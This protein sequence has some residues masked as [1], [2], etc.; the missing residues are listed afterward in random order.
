MLLWEKENYW[1]QKVRVAAWLT[2]DASYEWDSEMKNWIISSESIYYYSTPTTVVNQLANENILLYP[3]PTSG[4]L[5]I[6][7]INNSADIDVYSINGHMLK[8]LQQ[9]NYNIDMSEFTSGVYILRIRSNN[10][11]IV[12]KVIKD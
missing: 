3:N 11:T 12:R 4:R 7:G 9:V 6:A 8:S 2:H 1:K 5:K 10:K